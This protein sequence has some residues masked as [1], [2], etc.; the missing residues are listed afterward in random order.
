[1]TTPIPF[2]TT[3]DPR[4]IG[5]GSLDPLGL[6]QIADHLATQLV[7]AVRERMRRI[8]FL[9]A[10]AVGSLLTEDLDDEFRHRDSSPY[11]VWEWLVVEALIRDERMD[12]SAGSVPGSRVT[13]TAL[14]QHGYLD[15][16]SYL[17][18]PRVFGFHGVYKRLAVRLRLVDV[19]LG[20]SVEAER[21]VDAWARDRDMGGIAGAKGQ[22]NR[23]TTAVRRSLDHS[24]PRT[25][26]LW[27]RSDWAQIASSFA[28]QSAKTNEK[29]L[30][31]ELLLA[32]NDRQI[33]ALPDLWKLHANYGD[34]VF[35]EEALHA[36]LGH[37]VPVYQTI[38]AAIRTY[39]GFARGLQDAFDVLRG[40]A[41]KSDIRGYL[42]PQIASNGAFLKSVEHL[43]QRFA[44]A[45]NV[46]G[47][48]SSDL[49]SL[50]DARFGRLAEPMDAKSY[51]L[52][53]CD[54]HE[55]I[56]KEKS[57]DGKRAWF[58]RIGDDR[59]YLRHDY[60]IQPHEIAPASYLHGYRGWPI[61]S[62]RA[63]LT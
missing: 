58:D 50:F 59:I 23:W 21:L 52:A 13:R 26:P 31:R 46:L 35:R 1:M 12:V 18:T 15:A 60:R 55:S 62:F 6:Y 27:N 41:A 4:G 63:D 38:V 40:E 32:V 48:L 33:G 54:H 10:M 47:E 39:E 24:P 8:R 9:T 43:D 30:L 34:D 3:Y 22:L 5:E 29:R 28:P 44:A 16:R 49:Q 53:V 51:A 14:A 42:V 45:Y 17:K 7:P 57:E 2:L 61:R 56:Q 25:K 20:P 11:L 37:R 36:D 19:H